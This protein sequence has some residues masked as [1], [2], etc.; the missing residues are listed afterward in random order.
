MAVVD[1]KHA[2]FHAEPLPKTFVEL[3]DYHDLD[4]PDKMLRE[5]AALLLREEIGCKVVA[6]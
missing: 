3:P 1:V 4:S 2:Y 6:P 5:T